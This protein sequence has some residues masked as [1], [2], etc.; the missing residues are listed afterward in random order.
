MTERRHSTQRSNHPVT[1]I[2]AATG[3]QGTIHRQW[4]TVGNPPEVALY[5]NARLAAERTFGS[6]VPDPQD[7]SP[8]TDVTLTAGNADCT[9]GGDITIYCLAFPIK[10]DAI[11][12]QVPFA[13]KAQEPNK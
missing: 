6:R 3:N 4:L 13:L 1:A 5:N 10:T 2:R 8:I 9:R 12:V 7:L 11:H